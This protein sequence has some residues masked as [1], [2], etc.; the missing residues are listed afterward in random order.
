MERRDEEWRNI[1]GYEGL[2]QVSNIGRIRSLDRLVMKW[3]G[4]RIVHSQ[5]ISQIRSGNGYMSVTL[6]RDGKKHQVT[7]H[8]LVAIS[9]LDNPNNLPTINHKNGIRDDNRVDNL[10]WCSYSENNKHAFRVLGRN[11]S[12][13]VPVRCIETGD[14]FSSMTDAAQ[15]FGITTTSVSGVANGK[16]KQTHGLHFSFAKKE[17]L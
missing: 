17:T 3:N 8:R 14:V 13:A 10:E 7:V 11:N 1:P 2:Y 15:A 6:S 4:M 5:I 9:F 12:H 16:Y